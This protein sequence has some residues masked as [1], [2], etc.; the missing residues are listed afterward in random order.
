MASNIAQQ[1]ASS[2]AGV[3]KNVAFADTSDSG[4]SSTHTSDSGFATKSAKASGFVNAGSSAHPS[5]AARGSKRTA[6]I[7]SFDGD[8]SKG[9]MELVIADVVFRM[10]TLI[11]KNPEKMA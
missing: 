7:L 10:A 4:S 8:G 5:S 11:I 1:T 3:A 6:G 2:P 9:V